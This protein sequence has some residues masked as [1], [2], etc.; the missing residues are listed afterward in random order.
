MTFTTPSV[1][2]RLDR[3]LAGCPP[4]LVDTVTASRLMFRIVSLLETH[5]DEV[6][7]PFGLTMR[8]YL[9]LR[10]ISDQPNE[11]LRPS[12]LSST[13]DAPRPQITRLLDELE[14]KGLAQRVPCRGDRRSLQLIQTPAAQAL[15][16]EAS[17]AVHAVYMNAWAIPGP[18][19]TH[20]V[21]QHLISV[22]AALCSAQTV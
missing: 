5:I 18:D 15:L 16:E 22:H 17:P 12:D 14:R 6:L 4:T 2:S 3:M 20:E 11:P 1:L 21:V 13:L 10:L 9:A 8:E 19:G 7:K